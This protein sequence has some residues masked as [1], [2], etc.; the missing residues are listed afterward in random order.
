[1]KTGTVKTMMSNRKSPVN[2]RTKIP[3]KGRS[4]SLIDREIGSIVSVSFAS[5]LSM[6]SNI[7]STGIHFFCLQFI[8]D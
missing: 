4:I 6:P 5:V 2:I 8:P 7:S 3:V 1:M